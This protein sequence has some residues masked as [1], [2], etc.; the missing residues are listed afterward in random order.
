MMLHVSLD[1][2]RNGVA[3]TALWNIFGVHIIERFM[4]GVG[5]MQLLIKLL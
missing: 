2:A 5:V 1:T 4:R 3:A